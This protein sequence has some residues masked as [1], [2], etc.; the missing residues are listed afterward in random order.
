[1][2]GLIVDQRWLLDPATLDG[3]GATRVKVAAGGR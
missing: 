1:M 3:V 2:P